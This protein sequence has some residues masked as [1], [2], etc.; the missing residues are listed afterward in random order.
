MEFEKFNFTKTEDLEKFLKQC[1]T[2]KDTISNNDL[3]KTIIEL[4]DVDVY[5]YIDTMAEGAKETYNS[6]NFK[7][8]DKLT[9]FE[10]NELEIYEITKKR[11][12]TLIDKYIKYTFNE[13]DNTDI[14]DLEKIKPV[15]YNFMCWILKN[16]V[17]NIC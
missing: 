11:F 1:K 3:L 15:L 14:I 9:N 4:I 7:K 12:L 6:A 10:K 13:N 16:N 5:K 8:N 17:L 2:L